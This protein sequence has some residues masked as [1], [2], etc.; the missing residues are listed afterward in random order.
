MPS[1][2]VV[3]RIEE[4]KI[5]EQDEDGP[6]KTPQKCPSMLH[7]GAT[8]ATATSPMTQLSVGFALTTVANKKGKLLDYLIIYNFNP[9]VKIN[10]RHS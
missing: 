8:S 1:T 9:M 10:F 6:T 4:R 2:S 3:T 7:M 5:D